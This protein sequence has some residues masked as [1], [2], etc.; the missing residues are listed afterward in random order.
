MPIDPP[1]TANPCN[2]F[3]FL[4]LLLDY[5]DGPFSEVFSSFISAGG[6]GLRRDYKITRWRWCP[7]CGGQLGKY[8]PELA[9]A[10]RRYRAAIAGPYAA[11]MGRASE[12]TGFRTGCEALGAV[13]APHTAED[14]MY[15]EYYD[16]AAALKISIQWDYDH[17]C[18]YTYTEFAPDNSLRQD[19]FVPEPEL[20]S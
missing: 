12:P 17:N 9:E 2:C 1:G 5:P 20:V 3:T 14:G 8:R 13:L 7:G 18:W 16:A 6:Y 19:P 15:F 4:E 10:Y 11:L